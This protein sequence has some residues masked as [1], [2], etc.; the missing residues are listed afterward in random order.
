MIVPY[1]Q[2][3]ISD[4]KKTETEGNI[5][6]KDFETLDDEMLEKVTGGGAG[7]YKA[8]I[9]LNSSFLQPIK[10]PL[11]S[12]RV[13]IPPYSV[14]VYIDNV[15]NEE[16]SIRNEGFSQEPINPCIRLYG[17]GGQKTVRAIVNS[18]YVYQYLVDF[19]TRKIHTIYE[20]MPIEFI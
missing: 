12:G 18:K 13:L 11:G 4:D 19:D 7:E 10:D 5:T 1:I 17:T 20:G 6:G 14:E 16:F 2:K 8:I 9:Y 15:F 3:H